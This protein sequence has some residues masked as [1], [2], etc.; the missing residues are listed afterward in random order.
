MSALTILLISSAYM[1]GSISSAVLICRIMGLS[2]PRSHGSNNPGATNVYRIGGKIPAILTLLA[3][4]LK[5]TL[6][7]WLALSL[8]QK[9]LALGG[10]VIAACIGHIYPL[11]FGFNGGKG[12]ATALGTMLPLSIEISILLLLIWLVVLLLTGY[13]SLAAI[14]SVSSAPL[15][16]LW[17]L[18]EIVI[19]SFMLACI[20]VFRHHDNIG[21]LVSGNES[22]VYLSERILKNK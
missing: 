10:V 2:D 1:L 6:P 22:R 17:L 3:D 14:I 8:D 20:I 21:R 13:S 16:S 11:F 12:V 5:G 19:P 9:D 15:L 7:V 4:I 18:P